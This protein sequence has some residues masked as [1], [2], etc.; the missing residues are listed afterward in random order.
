MQLY[1][2]EK[3]EISELTMNRKMNL[4]LKSKCEEIIIKEIKE[5]LSKYS[6]GGLP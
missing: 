1:V 2:Q 3:Q 5:K 4:D 6:K